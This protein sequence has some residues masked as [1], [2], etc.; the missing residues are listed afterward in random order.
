MLRYSV[1]N[2]L[3]YPARL[4][5]VPCLILASSH[6]IA[7]IPLQHGDRLLMRSAV[8]PD[9]SL[10]AVSG[11]QTY[12]FAWPENS[13]PILTLPK[14]GDAV[15]SPSGKLLAVGGGDI[16]IFNLDTKGKA[17]NIPCNFNGMCTQVRLMHFLSEDMLLLVTTH[18]ISIWNKSSLERGLILDFQSSGIRSASITP[19]GKLLLLGWDNGVAK[20]LQKTGYAEYSVVKQIAQD[21]GGIG[22]VALRS[23]GRQAILEPWSGLIFWNLDSNQL[24]QID[25]IDRKDPGSAAV[26][27]SQ[28]GEIFARS[29]IGKQQIELRDSVTGSIIRTIA[30]QHN[31]FH[32]SFTPDSKGLVGVGGSPGGVGYAALWTRE[33]EDALAENRNKLALAEKQASRAA[34]QAVADRDAQARELRA[35]AAEVKRFRA[36]L[37]PEMLTNCGPIIELKAS[38]VKV[39]SPVKEYGNE[40]W[41]ARGNIFPQGFSCNWLNGR[42]RPPYDW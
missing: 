20:L 9:S 2:L 27:Y 42:Y 11:R 3:S 13:P 23:D 35:T 39:Y 19:D 5:V 18:T 30:T 6:C 28:G 22:N 29:V 36:S 33:V 40:H 37:K 31:T 17:Y 25:G 12:V 4:L 32:L 38:L 34:A 1:R 21:K 24:L 26:T 41:I 14:G 10:V 8:S 16:E 7:E 15:F